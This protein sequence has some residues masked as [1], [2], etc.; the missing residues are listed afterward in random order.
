M[1]PEKFV[2]MS[3]QDTANL[4]DELYFHPKKFIK[5]IVKQR[6][7]KNKRIQRIKSATYVS[8]EQL[9]R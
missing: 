1:R 2:K 7:T 6:N 3:V 8:E 5:L 9:D 4:L